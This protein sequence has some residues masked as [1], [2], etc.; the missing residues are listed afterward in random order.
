MG[1]EDKT[2][3][4]QPIFSNRTEAGRFLAAKLDEYANRS[5]V[6]VLA[7]P[8]GGVPVAFEVAK[9]LKAPLDVLIVRKLGVP[10]QEELAFGA[11]ASGGSSFFNEGLISALRLT[12]S[13]VETIVER[14][15]RELQ[16]R[17]RLYRGGQNT[18]LDARGKTVLIV[19]DGLATG[20]TMLAAIT[21][22]KEKSPKKV[23]VAVPVGSRQTCD[24]FKREA[25]VWCVCAV[26]PEPFYGV[27][28]WYEDFTQTADEEVI[29]LLDEAKNFE[30]K[31][32]QAA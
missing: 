10:G 15:R 20:A 21:A 14:E 11:I 24:E 28:I 4:E 23:V 16:R 9:T 22:I 1:N 8:R 7:L 31:I 29:K 6:I 27:G 12:D 2:M 17:E 19:D 13:M 26:T 32:R 3:R 18:V 5:D 25:D 30:N